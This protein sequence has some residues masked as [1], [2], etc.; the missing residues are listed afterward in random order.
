MKEKVLWKFDISVRE[1]HILRTDKQE[2]LFMAEFSLCPHFK[3]RICSINEFKYF[4]ATDD[5]HYDL[6]SKRKQKMMI[7]FRFS[8]CRFFIWLLKILERIFHGLHREDQY[9]K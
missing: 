2:F 8:A 9:R 5:F 1:M 3:L 6:I 7:N 4:I